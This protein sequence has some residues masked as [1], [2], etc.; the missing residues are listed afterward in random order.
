MF[1][2][3][4][5]QELSV[6]DTLVGDTSTLHPLSCKYIRKFSKKIKTAL[7]VYSGAW[8]KLIH[9]K[10]LKSKISWHYPFKPQIC[11]A[12]S[13]PLSSIYTLYTLD[14]YIYIRSTFCTFRPQHS[15]LHA[16]CSGDDL[17]FAFFNFS[18]SSIIKDASS[19]FCC[20]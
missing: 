4:N 18:S 19:P 8:G 5:I 2:G 3:R 10:N 14:N 9:G 6:G 20:I 11:S 13:L 15:D 1:K 16:T 12:K 17:I 7:M